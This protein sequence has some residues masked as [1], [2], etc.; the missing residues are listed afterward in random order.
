MGKK[1]V[2]LKRKTEDA[3]ATVCE[4]VEQFGKSEM[5]IHISNVIGMLRKSSDFFDNYEDGKR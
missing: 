2:F 3:I 5:N 1:V 4:V